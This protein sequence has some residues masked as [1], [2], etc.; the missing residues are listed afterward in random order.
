MK[1][2][3]TSKGSGQNPTWSLS[4]NDENYHSINYFNFKKDNNG[5]WKA[6]IN[7]LNNGSYTMF[8]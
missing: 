3:V 5:Y 1:L 7:D 6:I 2:E 8:V 4:V